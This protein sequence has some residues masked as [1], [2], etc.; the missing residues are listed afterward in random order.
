MIKPSIA[1]LLGCV[2]LIGCG[3]QPSTEAP[4]QPE[5]EAEVAVA[6][7]SLVDLVERPADFVDQEI[8]V[9]GTVDH[10]C[11]HGGKRLFI[12]AENPEQRF[13]IEAG[14]PIGAF[15]V[16]LEGSDV[17]VRGVVVENRID[18]AYLDTMEADLEAEGDEPAGEQADTDDHHAQERDHLLQL[19]QQVAESENGYLSTYS[20]DCQALETIGE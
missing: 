13:K 20:L 17:K 9:Q 3:G 11:K 19:R 16:A 15:D 18:D 6:E 12:M 1:V 10:V 4:V 14:E 7:V 8:F 5:P 2:V